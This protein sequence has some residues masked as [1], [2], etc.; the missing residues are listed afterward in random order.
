MKVTHVTALATLLGGLAGFM[1][2]VAA[3]AYYLTSSKSFG[4]LQLVGVE[5]IYIATVAFILYYTKR[6]IR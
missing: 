6:R 1:G 5:V 4:S 2:V 3:I